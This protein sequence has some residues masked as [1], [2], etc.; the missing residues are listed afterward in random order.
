MTTVSAAMLLLAGLAGA[1][2]AE[3]FKLLNITDPAPELK[4]AKW[5]KGEPVARLAPGGIYVIEFWATWCGP[6]KQ[7]I[8]HITEL[9]EKYRGKATFI[10]VD[11]L[12]GDNET[13]QETLE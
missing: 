1:P 5:I 13:E 11:V 9:A 7:A 6:C 12:E 10:G 4:V 3:E 2:A 8:P